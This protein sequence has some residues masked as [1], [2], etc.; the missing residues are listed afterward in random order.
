MP[1]THSD[2]KKGLDKNVD[3]LCLPVRAS[4]ALKE[5]PED[6]GEVSE[7]PKEGESGRSPLK[8][9]TREI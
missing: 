3:S 8:L 7:W 5:A 9:K 4:S 1:G 6:S 2:E